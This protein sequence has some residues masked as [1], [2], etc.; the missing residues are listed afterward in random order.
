MYASR[1]LLQATVPEYCDASDM[2]K[3]AI[4]LRTILSDLGFVQDNPTC[5]LINNTGAVF[6]VN[7]QAP[8]KRTR[9]VDIRYFGLLNWSHHAG[10]IEAK[11]IS[12]DANISDSL[13]SLTKATGEIK[14]HQHAD[15]FMGKV[16]PTYVPR[17]TNC[18]P[19]QRLHKFVVLQIT[20]V[21]VPWKPFLLCII[22]SSAHR[23][24]T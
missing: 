1:I 7:A 3:A 13:A 18:V 8:T 20:P 5:L 23:A 12:T 21:Q 11:A 14:F 4:C 6:M 19:V 24:T 9:H 17:I 15:I 22:N 16:P 10:Q 2:G